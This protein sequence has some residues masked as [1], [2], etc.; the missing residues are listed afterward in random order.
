MYTTQA[1]KLKKNAEK[2]DTKLAIPS[3]DPLIFKISKNYQD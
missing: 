1:S 3:I 2:N